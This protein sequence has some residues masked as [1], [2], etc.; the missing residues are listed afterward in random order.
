MAFHF[1]FEAIKKHPY[2]IG[3][4]IIA[5][6]LLIFYLLSKSGGSS[7]A[8]SDGGVGAAL[9]YDEQM[10]QVN[11]G[12]TAQQNQNQTQLAQS[13][14]EAQVSNTQTAASLQ[15]QNNS[16]AAQLADNI[17]GIVGSIY[18]TNANTVGNANQLVYTE[19]VQNMTDSVL[20]DQINSGVVENANNNATALGATLAGDQMYE[21]NVQTLAPLFGKSY[22]TG[23]DANRAF[24]EIE[25]VLTGGNPG[26]AT[27]GENLVQGVT[28]SG[29]N[30][31]SSITNSVAGVI[32]KLL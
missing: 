2:A 17:A 13:Q 29:N 4:A 20:E 15:A 1:D 27:G 16:T 5:G 24:G 14:L 8:A 7:T 31:A 9:Q 25:T 32:S 3:G 23:N 22:N 12:L 26:V 19:N 21:N 11:A 6:G 28:T 10:A 18:Q 30:T